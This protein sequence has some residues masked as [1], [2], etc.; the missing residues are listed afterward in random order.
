MGFPTLAQGVIIRRP[1]AVALAQRLRVD[2]RAVRLL[3]QLRAR[4][5][6]APLRLSIPGRSVA[7]VLDGDD[8]ERLLSA[9]TTEIATTTPEKQAALGHF[10]PHGV[11]AS[12]GEDRERR[13]L[14]NE[15][16]LQTP[17]ALHSA[18][19]ALLQRVQR[20]TAELLT[21][22]DTAGA[23]TWDRFATAWWR[24]VRG[25]IFGDAARLD[26]RL[27]DDLAALRSRANWAFARRRDD[28]RRSRFHDAVRRYLDDP[29]PGTLAEAIAR[30]H[31]TPDLAAADQVAHWLFAFDAA[32]IATFRALAL[33]AAHPADERWVREEFEADASV[34][35]VLDRARGCVLEAVRLWPTTPMI[36]RE[37][38]VDL[39]WHGERYP[40]GTTFVVYAPLFH[41][42]AS[43][44]EFADTF[45]P[46]IWLDGQAR[47]H[48]E[49]VPFSAGPGACPGRNIVLFTASTTLAALMRTHSYRVQAGADLSDPVPPSLD[50]FHLVLRARPFA[51]HSRG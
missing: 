41:R 50:H 33:L 45:A 43:T 23:L 46:R 51:E 21:E 25:V 27:T 30:A 28:Q 31:P 2:E 48:P 38:A 8:V 49:L 12:T 34:P 39:T 7:V 9:P 20:E 44:L 40:Q 47:R 3:S 4:R 22:I 35:R 18:A 17:Q 26:D 29:A 32:G 19:P 11:L 10:Q 5:G 1:V 16:A 37:S 13:R 14:F 24:I 15:T 36:L 42:D 6:P